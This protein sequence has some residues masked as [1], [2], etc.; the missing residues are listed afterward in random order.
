MEVKPSTGADLQQGKRLGPVARDPCQAQSQGEAPADLVGLRIAVLQQLPETI[1][2]FDAEAPESGRRPVVD[3]P[4][5][6]MDGVVGGERVVAPV[7]HQVVDRREQ[8][9]GATL[10]GRGPQQQ[11]E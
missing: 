6:A 4:S 5:A 7:A 1:S 9:A 8:Q 11:F 10:A 2:M 3:G